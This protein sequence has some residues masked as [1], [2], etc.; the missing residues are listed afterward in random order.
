MDGAEVEPPF[1]QLLNESGEPSSTGR[2]LLLYNGGTVCDDSFSSDSAEAICREL[3]F[4]MSQSYSYSSGYRWEYLQ[5]NYEITL[6]E[7]ACSSG[8][9]EECSYSAAHDCSHSEDIFLNCTGIIH[10]KIIFILFSSDSGSE[11][12]FSSPRAARGT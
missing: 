12:S 11:N 4:T 2:G 7:V 3:G 5:N 6:D 9:W 1:F 8:E 10:I